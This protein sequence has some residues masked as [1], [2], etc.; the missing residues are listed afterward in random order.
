VFE[1]KGYAASIEF[2][3]EARLFHGEVV[4]TRDVVTF[5]GA[6]VDE[7][8]R[9]FRDSVD[10]YLEFC[11]QRGEEPD[12]PFSGNVPLRIGPDLHRRV[13]LAAA[14]SGMSVNAW[15]STVI[16]KEATALPSPKRSSGFAQA[17]ARPR[18]R[19]PRHPRA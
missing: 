2:D 12:K 1:Y 16:E 18:P 10:D 3:D 14:S 15:L 11:R 8:E 4:G 9:A 17:G 19:S 13:Y 7:L 5:E 6:S